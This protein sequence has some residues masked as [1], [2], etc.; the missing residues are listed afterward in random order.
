MAED[1]GAQRAGGSTPAVFVS[2]ASPDVAVASAFVDALERHG[3]PCWIAP[4]DVIPGALYADEIV[5]AINDA[6]LVVLILSGHA[7]ASSHV[8]KEIERASSKGRRIIALR[9]DAAPLPPA[10]EYFLSESQWIDVGPTGTEAAA[11]KLVEAVRRHLEP[12]DGA[13]AHASSHESAVNRATAMTLLRGLSIGSVAVAAVVLAYVVTHPSWWSMRSATPAAGPPESAATVGEQAI[14]VLPFADLSDGHDQQYFADGMAQE[15]TDLLAR[16]PGLRVIGRTSAFQFSGASGDPRSIGAKLGASFLVEGSVR[17]S[18]RHL[19]VSAQLI[20]SADGSQRWSDTYDRDVDDVFTVQDAIAAATARALNISVTGGFE[21]RAPLRSSVAYDLYLKGVRALDTGSKEGCE[22]AIADFQQALSIDAAYA[23][24]AVGLS[25][26]YWY[27]AEF[28]WLPAASAM[29]RARA[30]AD[31]AIELDPKLG[32]PHAALAQVH[33]IYDWDWEGAAKEVER[34]RALGAGVEGVK[35][36]ARL[37]ATTG[38]WDEATRVLKAGL[39]IDPLNPTLHWNLAYV[40]YLRA[41]RLAETEAEVRRVLEISPRFGFAHFELGLA[42]LLQGRP[43]EA[44]T[45]FREA[46]PDDGRY[47]GL[48]IAYFAMGQ[49]GESDAMLQR[50]VEQDAREWPYGLA[51]AYAFRGQLDQAMYWLERAY[52]QRDSSLY[53]IKGDPLLKHLGGEPRYRAFMQKLRLPV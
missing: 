1:T 52:S 26:A 9:T 28:D 19:R 31:K 34:A 8:G 49:Q 24:A 48:A 6:K 41:G 16:T 40:V 23:Q 15:I 22:E 25:M 3:I 30:A 2:H 29:E 43:N 18:G 46:D 14:A 4:R 21:P 37:A 50:A 27:S 32:T 35:A 11:A 42:L 45:A 10:F 33:L 53:T 12:G 20:A 39:A 38:N 47:E 51:E 5:G 13:E 36:E 7:I 44:V 17:R